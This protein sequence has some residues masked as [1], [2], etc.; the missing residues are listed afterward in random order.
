MGERFGPRPIWPAVLISGAAFGLL[1]LARLDPAPLY[2]PFLPP[3]PG[4]LLGTDN[5]GRDVLA[6]LGNASVT[7]LSIGIGAAMGATLIGA[8]IGCVAGYWRS[9]ADD[10]LMRLTDVFLLIPTLPLI[11]VLA[12]YLGPGAV[13]TTLAITLTAWPA[14][15]R[16]VR[17]R[18]LSL[19]QAPFV[20]NAH[21]MGAGSAV[22]IRQHIVPNCGELLQ[23][24]ASLSVAGAMLAEAGIGFLGLGDP[25][26][27]SW[28][29]MIHD[30]FAAGALVNGYW[31]WVLPPMGLISLAVMGFNLAAGAAMSPLRAGKTARPGPHRLDPSSESGLPRKPID[32]SPPPL[33][34]VSGLTI[35]FAGPSSAVPVVDQLDLAVRPGEKIAVI[36]ATGSGKSLLLL[37]ILGLLPPEAHRA[38]RIFLAGDD[39]AGF[40]AIER[41]RYRGLTA[42]YIP[43]GIGEA[44]N[45]VLR[46]VRQVA[47][48]RR[49]HR[50]STRRQAYGDALA[51]MQAAGL[52]NAARYARGYP[53]HLS[54]GMKQRILLAM[55]LA[56]DPV[57]LLADEPTKGLDPQA[58]AAVAALL[59]SLQDKAVLAVTH[60]LG[61]AKALGGRVVV[62]YAGTV[63]EDTTASALIQA[64]MHPYTQALVAAQPA[65]GL[66]PPPAVAAAPA[67]AG[68]C[69]FRPRCPVADKRCAQPPLLFNHGG[70]AI[71]CWR[72]AS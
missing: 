35:R 2:A 24:K 19:R 59:R 20:I 68:G 25:L 44:M 41:R 22:L 60:D 29:S 57:L 10:L 37:S 14:T 36:G 62:M 46:V 21:S 31:W 8:L 45:P 67:T 63:V 33:L 16:V 40:S 12:A 43:Q 1:V 17:A 23:A 5:S 65:H 48:R 58:V 55:A 30:A 47:E 26:H 3:G 49:V 64:P 6:L 72:H 15:A 38:G 52:K 56:G 71:R 51:R 42:A 70:H 11:V 27:P 34:T 32:D 50:G 61:F 13:H 54:G 28:G 9:A 7:S 18:V 4:H 66:H 39:I 53:H 69:H